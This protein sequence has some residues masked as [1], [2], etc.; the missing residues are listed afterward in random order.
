MAP[1]FSASRQATDSGP[2][3]DYCQN[4]ERVGTASK[5]WTSDMFAKCHSEPERESQ[6]DLRIE[7]M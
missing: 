4:A 1:G 5:S 7:Q 3:D 2:A 6:C